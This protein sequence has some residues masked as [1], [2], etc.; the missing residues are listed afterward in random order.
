MRIKKKKKKREYKEPYHQIQNHKTTYYKTTK[1]AIHI[2]L[3]SM[4]RIDFTKKT[5]LQK[6]TCFF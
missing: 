4:Y 1:T 5:A 6:E 3:F 2:L